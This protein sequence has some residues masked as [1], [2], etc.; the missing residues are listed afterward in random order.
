MAGNRVYFNLLS[1]NILLFVLN[2]LFLI[3]NSISIGVFEVT[4]FHFSTLS[5]SFWPFLAFLAISMPSSY[6]KSCDPSNIDKNENLL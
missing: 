1:K 5:T 6:I 2:S 4:N 3:G